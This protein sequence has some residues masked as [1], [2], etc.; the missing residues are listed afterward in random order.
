MKVANLHPAYN[1]LNL[2][3][4]LNGDSCSNSY[5]Y[6]RKYPIWREQYQIS[7][8]LKIVKYT[9]YSNYIAINLKFSVLIL[10]V[11]SR[12]WKS[13]SLIICNR[14][15]DT[16][17]F[18]P[19]QQFYLVETITG[20]LKLFLKGQRITSLGSPGQYCLCCKY[21]NSADLA[22]EQSWAIWGNW[23]GMAVF[24]Q[25]FIYKIRQQVCRLQFASMTLYFHVFFLFEVTR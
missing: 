3:Q 15:G 1:I 17:F 9:F 4:L 8:Q 5:L 24:Q 12:S 18:F 2:T 10:K 11:T 13:L 6:I 16:C 20:I 25:N 19:P 14:S 23:V 22:Q 7:T 21:S